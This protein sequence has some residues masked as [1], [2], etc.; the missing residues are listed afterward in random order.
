MAKTKKTVTETETEETFHGEF[1]QVMETLAEAQWRIQQLRDGIQAR[2]E[3]IPEDKRQDR[4]WKEVH[5]TAT[6]LEEADGDLEGLVWQEA[7]LSVL[8]A[9]PKKVKRIG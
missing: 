5:A 9:K 2:L 4:R 3:K 7:D 1:K 6:W 8:D